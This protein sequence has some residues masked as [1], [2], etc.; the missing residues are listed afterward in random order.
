MVRTTRVRTMMMPR[1]GLALLLMLG[2]L[3]GQAFAQSGEDRGAPMGRFD[4]YVLSLSWSPSFCESGGG[5]RSRK[6]CE[7]DRNPGFVVHGLWPQ[8]ERGFP[9][10]CRP[11]GRGASQNAMDIGTRVF[12]DPSLARYQWQKHGSC[13]GESPAGYFTAAGAARARIAIPKQFNEPTQAIRTTTIEIER[14]FAVANPGLRP[15]MMAVACKRGGVL[16][17]VRICMTRD[18]RQFRPCDE[19]S[20]QACRT[21][22][23][24]VPSAR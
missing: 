14:A 15:D 23:I 7:I 24:T 10:Y 5:R 17:E 3:S 18:L 1:L 4:F 20:R 13:S 22:E 21:R 6:Q 19:V 8:Y 9:S 2:F 16:E 11:D 12:P